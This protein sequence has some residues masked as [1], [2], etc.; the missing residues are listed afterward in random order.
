MRG[1]LTPGEASPVAKK[2]CK[3]THVKVED[4]V[5]GAPDL[6]SDSVVDN[7]SVVTELKNVSI[8][9]TQPRTPYFT[10]RREQVE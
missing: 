2:R 1:A 3:G 9:R 6:Y 5:L 8:C 7:N 10:Q 4:V